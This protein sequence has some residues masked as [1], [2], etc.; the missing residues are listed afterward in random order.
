MLSRQDWE[1]AKAAS[2]DNLKQAEM[3]KIQAEL[4][5]HIAKQELAKCKK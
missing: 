4:L 1:K 3:I 2:E 5:L